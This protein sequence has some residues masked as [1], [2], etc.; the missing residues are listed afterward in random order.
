MARTSG[1][2]GWSQPPADREEAKVIAAGRGASL[3]STKNGFPLARARKQP[4]VSRALIQVFAF[5]LLPGYVKTTSAEG[6][7]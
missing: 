2:D 3:E 5:L 4:F 1:R 6:K 7:R